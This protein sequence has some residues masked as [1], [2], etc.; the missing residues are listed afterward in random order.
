MQRRTF[1]RNL[2]ILSGSA[3]LAGR[4]ESVVR[5]GT[6]PLRRFKLGAISDGF[7]Q[8]LEEALKRMKGYGLSWVEIRNVWGIYNTEASPAQ[9]RRLKD[10]LAKYEF[11]VSVVDTALFKCTLPGTKLVTDEKDVYPY[12]GQ[13]DLQ[14]GRAS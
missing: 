13:K 7:S 3:W 12:S 5:A 8:D 10:L 2:G 6:S 9:I 11:K 14:I 1:L 4:C